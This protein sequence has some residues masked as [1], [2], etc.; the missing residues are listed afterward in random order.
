[1]TKR[2]MALFC[3][4]LAVLALVT[5][6][7]LPLKEPSPAENAPAE[8]ASSAETIAAIDTLKIAYNNTD[9]LNPYL[10]TGTM[11]L[12]VVP[13][14]YDPLVKLDE[15]Y[16]VHN[17]LAEKIDLTPEQCTVTLRKDVS[18][19]NGVRL[20]A[21]DVV[22]SAKQVLTGSN[23][24]HG[25][26]SNVKDVFATDGYTVV[27]T[28]NKPDRLFACMLT[29]PI[30]C[31]AAPAVGSG[32]YVLG[33]TGE[34]TKLTR[35]TNWFGGAGGQ[36]KNIELVNQ[37]D[38]DTLIYSMKLGAINY[39][40]SDLS[41][42]E[43]LSLGISTQSVPLNNFIFL[44]INSTKTTLGDARM[45][46]VLTLCINRT[47][48]VSGA[49]A[50]RATPA[51]TPFNP[52]IPEIRQLGVEQ[53]QD[54]TSAARLMEEMGYA[55]DKKDSEG[56]YTT[57]QGRLR[58]RL[59]VNSENSS[60]MQ[61]ALNLQKSL[62]ELGIEAVIEAKPFA[63]YKQA[64]EQWNFDLYLG[65][66]KLYNNRDISALL[67]G[68]AALGFG[69]TESETLL[70]AN[71]AMMAG[72]ME[73]KA[74]VEEFN[75]HLPFLPL[76]YRSGMVAFSREIFFEGSATEQDIFYNIENW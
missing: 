43:A 5:G 16:A 27:F 33:G 2:L 30:V 75:R 28:L 1:M 52:V 24:Y 7:S 42:N 38:K 46:Q 32:R 72:T 62:K 15:Q 45:R 18:F 51:H 74:F 4:L 69:V 53:I 23:S 11:N 39:V 6:C 49:Y 29:F 35:N 71:S 63:E 40:Y 25:L 68:K 3:A 14:L 12:N 59:L 9:S 66:V 8:S 21:A 26:L 65:E 36:I 55:A 50:A 47:E 20:N 44:G 70:A 57:R 19:T 54:F 41:G 67:S 37:L 61:L 64:L 17:V 76:M 60:R 10:A 73:V 56:Y 48:L 31:E 13:L 22:Y 58:L 34:N